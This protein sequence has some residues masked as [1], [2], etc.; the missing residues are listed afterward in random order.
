MTAPLRDERPAKDDPAIAERL[1]AHRMLSAAPQAELD[2]LI[3]R[4]TL[5][6]VL[7]GDDVVTKGEPVNTLYF[8]LKGRVSALAN[9]GGTWRKVMDWRDGDATG[10]YPYSRITLSTREV[11]AVDERTEFMCIDR[12]DVDQMPL[13]CPDVTA[14][15][16]HAMVDRAR[17]F[18]ENDLEGEKVASLGRVAAGL[19]H[20]LNNPASAATRGA[21]LFGDA[22]AEAEDAARVL[23]AA[24]LTESERAAVERARGNCLQIRRRAP[25]R[26]IAP[27]ERKRSPSGSRG[28]AS[29]TAA[30]RCSPRRP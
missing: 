5:G 1:R 23:G 2:W 16:V 20:E 13:A 8:V 26:S 9:V 15:L 24:Q 28:T 11:R 4:G 14:A 22:I 17:T 7:P 21:K 30:R 29:T 19:A 6:Y 10:V 27:T 25:R 18:K 3:E 12:A